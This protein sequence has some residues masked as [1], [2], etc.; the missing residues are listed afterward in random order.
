MVRRG[1]EDGGQHDDGTAVAQQLTKARAERGA[2]GKEGCRLLREEAV[3]A[4]DEGQS[5]GGQRVALGHAT[6]QQAE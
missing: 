4:L 1:R 2:V 5:N 3:D 6:A